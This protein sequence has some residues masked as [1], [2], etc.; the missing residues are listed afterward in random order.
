MTINHELKINCIPSNE[1]CNNV[2]FQSLWKYIFSENGV[3]HTSHNSLHWQTNACSLETV[4][5][6]DERHDS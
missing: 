1:V 5:Q 6:G 2:W 4:C 3:C